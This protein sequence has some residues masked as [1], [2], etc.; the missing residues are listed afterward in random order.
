MRG[1]TSLLWRFECVLH[2]KSPLKLPSS[3]LLKT[4]SNKNGRCY[5]SLC[6]QVYRFQCKSCQCNVFPLVHAYKPNDYFLGFDN[7][8]TF[9]GTHV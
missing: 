9:F 5:V 3:I 8:I 2:K 1:K 6:R 4:S 7:L